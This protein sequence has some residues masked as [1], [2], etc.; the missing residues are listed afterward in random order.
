MTDGVSGP[1]SMEYSVDLVERV[2]GI[3]PS[4]ALRLVYF[5]ICVIL[6]AVVLTPVWV[7]SVVPRLTE[8]IAQG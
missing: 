1:D 8:Y 5:V 2:G 6:L 4:D 7:R 3:L